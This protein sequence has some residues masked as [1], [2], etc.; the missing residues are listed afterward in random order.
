M[1]AKQSRIKVGDE[2]GVGKGILFFLSTITLHLL[3]KY[4]VLSCFFSLFIS[5]EYPENFPEIWYFNIWSTLDDKE[6][7]IAHM[8]DPIM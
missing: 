2:G 7:M 1:N 4:L 8:K 5:S 6:H 3:G